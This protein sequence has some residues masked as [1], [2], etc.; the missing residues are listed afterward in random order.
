MVDAYVVFVPGGINDTFAHRFLLYCCVRGEG[1][2]R[3]YNIGSRDFEFDDALKEV[4]VCGQ[5]YSCGLFEAW[6]NGGI[7]TGTRFELQR[8]DGGLITLYRLDDER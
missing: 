7:E 1:M 5:R 8:N 6:G 3:N 4:R 2:K